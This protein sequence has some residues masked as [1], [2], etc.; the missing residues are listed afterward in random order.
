M[1]GGHG[2]VLSLV[3]RFLIDHSAV[4]RA[5]SPGLG[6]SSPEVMMQPVAPMATNAVSAD[7]IRFFIGSPLGLYVIGRGWTART[8]V[9]SLVELR[10]SLDQH[11]A[12][13]CDPAQITRRCRASV[14]SSPREARARQRPSSRYLRRSRDAVRELARCR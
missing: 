13:L 2:R 4:M 7:T 3:A 5:S 14:H 12:G 9:A 6:S 11:R 1:P 8:Q 10:Q